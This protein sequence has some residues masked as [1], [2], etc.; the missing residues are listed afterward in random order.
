MALITDRKNLSLQAEN[1][2]PD[3]KGN[4]VSEAQ[5]TVLWLVLNTIAIATIC[6]LN[7]SVITKAVTQDKV[8]LQIQF[9][10]NTQTSFPPFSVFKVWPLVVAAG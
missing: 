1:L 3:Q 9:D 2:Q 4:K 6:Q 5:C 7:P 10:P 8:L